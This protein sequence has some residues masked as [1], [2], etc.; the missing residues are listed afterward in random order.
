[1][2]GGFDAYYTRLD[3]RVRDVLRRAMMLGAERYPTLFSAEN[4]YDWFTP[5]EAALV[6]VLYRFGSVPLGRLD[7][8]ALGA[9]YVSYVDEIDRDRLGQFFTPRDVVAFML[10]RVGFRGPDGLFSVEGDVRRPL[11]IFD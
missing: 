9:L 8:D 11:R 7:R 10:D 4:N 5:G 2:D 3:E 1:Y 6:E